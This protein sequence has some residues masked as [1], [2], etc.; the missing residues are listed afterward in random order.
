MCNCI[1]KE[2]LD[3]PRLGYYDYVFL[4]KKLDGQ[5]KVITITSTNDSQAKQLAE[6]KC[7]KEEENKNDQ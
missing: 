5:N 6:Q 2:K 3:N 4:C 7:S 1:Q